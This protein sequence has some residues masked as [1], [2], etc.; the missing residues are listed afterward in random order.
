MPEFF[1]HK[2]F[3]S[4]GVPYKVYEASDNDQLK[5][6]LKE[7]DKLQKLPTRFQVI[8]PPKSLSDM[9]FLWAFI[10][11]TP[12]LIFSMF[13]VSRWKLQGEQK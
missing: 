13:E 10:F 9:A 4:I 5:N 1:L 2:Y 3:Q 8:T 12:F 7:I 6:A 11:F